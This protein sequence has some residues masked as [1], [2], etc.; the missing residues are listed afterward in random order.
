MGVPADGA[1]AGAVMPEELLSR[2][3]SHYFAQRDPIP[4]PSKG[5]DQ[6]DHRSHMPRTLQIRIASI[7]T[8]WLV[9]NF[10]SKFVF[11]RTTEPS[12]RARILLVVAAL[13]S[14][15]ALVPTGSSAQT[16][17]EPFITIQPSAGP[18]GTLVVITLHNF[19]PNEE[20]HAILRV[21]GDPVV[22]TGTTDASGGGQ[23]SFSFP[24]QPNGLY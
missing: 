14:L 5:G 21:T 15:L 8:P 23:L 6:G 24:S 9:T 20:V 10:G 18:P 19:K 11:T 2:E 1:G 22:A 17:D 16:V 12:M 13:L 7:Q 4:H 3:P